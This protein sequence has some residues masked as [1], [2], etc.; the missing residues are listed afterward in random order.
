MDDIVVSS[1][2]GCGTVRINR[3]DRGNS[4]TPDVVR[5]MG[6]AVQ[7]LA[8]TDGVGAVVLT[9]TGRVFCAG[10]DVREMYDVYTADGPDALMDYLADIWM[11][12]V[13][14]TVRQLWNAPLP[15]IAAYNGAATAGGLDFGLACDL[16]IAASTAKFAESYVNLGMVPVA[17][18]AYLLPPLIGLAPASRMIASGA[19][20]TA[21][22][23]LELGM[24][25]EVCSVDDLDRR[26][27]EVATEMM[28]GPVATYA[29]AK[30]VARA[31]ATVELE[32][33]LQESLAANIDLIARPEVRKGILAVMERYSQ[34]PS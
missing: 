20:I 31:A 34:S 33:A 8:D 30:R 2:D 22:E 4:V 7:E 1:A 6:E 12:A 11:P 25:S 28:H 23:A 15:V 27:R 18:G 14:V 32:A 19:F 3:P 16:R 13:Q 29:R 26:A 10:A 17:G 21:D 5:R 9:G 24:V